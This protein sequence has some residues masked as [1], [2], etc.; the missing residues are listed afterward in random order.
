MLICSTS[1]TLSSYVSTLTDSSSFV[2]RSVSVELCCVVLCCVYRLSLPSLS[3]PLLSPPVMQPFESLLLRLLTCIGDVYYLLLVPLLCLYLAIFVSNKLHSHQQQQR[4]QQLPLQQPT[5]SLPSIEAAAE[6]PVITSHSTSP[7]SSSSHTSPLALDT[8]SSL[9]DSDSS[10]SN[11]PT[12]SPSSPTSS[13]LSLTFLLP[14]QSLVRHSFPVTTP[15]STVISTLYPPP[16][17]LTTS[18]RLIYQGRLLHS[19][20]HLAHYNMAA[21][22]MVHV[23]LLHAAH[24][25]E[26]AIAAA[27]SSGVSEPPTA[28]V[29]VLA[30]MCAALGCGWGVFVV[31]GDVLFDMASLAVLLSATGLTAVGVLYAHACTVSRRPLVVPM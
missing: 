13:L 6:S 30:L 20:T 25:T 8:D 5:H 17:T 9:S 29:A 15:I 14:D 21:H 11:A 23:H 28:L 10:S 1:Q 26:A 16:S 22:D 27:A 2:V 7:S 19:T 31:C 4:Q 3:S 12:S 18:A 24:S